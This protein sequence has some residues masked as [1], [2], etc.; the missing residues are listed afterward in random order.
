MTPTARPTDEN[1]KALRAARRGRVKA[2][3]PDEDGEIG[4]D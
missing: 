2:K 3:L 1:Q 4:G